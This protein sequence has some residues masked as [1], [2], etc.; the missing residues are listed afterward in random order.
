MSSD[1]RGEAPAVTEDSDLALVIRELYKGRVGRN[2]KTSDFCVGGALCHY[3]L[4]YDNEWSKMQKPSFP[5]PDQI[6]NDLEWIVRDFGSE[7]MQRYYFGDIEDE[8]WDAGDV[9]DR[10]EEF[11]ETLDYYADAIIGANDLGEYDD[12]W[13][14]VD[15]FL[16]EFEID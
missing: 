15:M 10:E 5:F 13:I 3:F 16:K 2:Q 6:V 12:A 7:R 14:H 1:M 4:R 9:E 11:T 8:Y